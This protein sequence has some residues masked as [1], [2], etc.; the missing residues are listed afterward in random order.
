MDQPEYTRGKT[1]ARLLEMAEDLI[2]ES[3]WSALSVRALGKRLGISGPAFYKHYSGID[4]LREQLIAKRYADFMSYVNAYQ[5]EVERAGDTE[6]Q[7]I[8]SIHQD[9][10]LYIQY[11][12]QNIRWFELYRQWVYEQ[13]SLALSLERR[14]DKLHQ[15]VAKLLSRGPQTEICLQACWLLE[16]SWFGL[17]Q[18]AV[19]EAQKGQA[20][21]SQ[22]YLAAIESSCCFL[23]TQ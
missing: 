1:K 14:S 10:L 12:A 2:L 8:Q 9:G 5:P 13:K 17:A 20:F 4:A 15:D 6:T 11:W 22:R 3:G 23:A 16:C 7:R 18:A 21:D 19:A